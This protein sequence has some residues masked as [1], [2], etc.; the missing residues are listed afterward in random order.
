[1]GPVNGV[2]SSPRCHTFTGGQTRA[3]DA[4]TSCRS[5]PKVSKVNTF[6]AD[7]TLTGIA[8]QRYHPR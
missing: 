4:D 1:M 6:A 5:G 7:Y 8:F 2:R 3:A